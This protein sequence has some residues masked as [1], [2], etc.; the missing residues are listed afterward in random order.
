MASVVKQEMRYCK[1]CGHETM[2][3]KNAKKMSW[4]VHLLLTIITGGFWLIIWIPLTILHIFN[5]S[6]TSL[7]SSWTCSVCGSKN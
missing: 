2:H 6:L 1:N 7:A 5:K 4:I 3:L